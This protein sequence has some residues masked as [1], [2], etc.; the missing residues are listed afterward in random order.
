MT[1][2]TMRMTVVISVVAAAIPLRMNVCRADDS[3]TG[4]A[5]CFARM[6]KLAGDWVRKDPQGKEMLVARYRT[7][8]GGTA[9]E[10]TLMP[11]SEEMV[12]IY[13]MDGDNLVMTHYCSMGNQPHLKATAGSTPSKIEF[14]CSGKGGNMKSENDMHIHHALFTLTE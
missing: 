1:I 11:G 9:L 14:V 3:K 12:S 10:E 8:S 5:A 13:Y 4:Q 6:K 7:I 2:R